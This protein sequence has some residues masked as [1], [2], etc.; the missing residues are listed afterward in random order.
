[1]K[2]IIF[3]IL[4]NAQHLYSQVNEYGAVAEFHNAQTVLMHKPSNE[5]YYGIIH[6]NAALFDT[7]FNPDQAAIEHQKF[8][9]LLTSNGVDVITLKSVLLKGTLD[10]NQQIIKGKHLDNLRDFAR[11]CIR[12]SEKSLEDFS[13]KEINIQNAYLDSVFNLMDP[14]NLVN[15]ILLQPTLTLKKTTTN[16]YLTA[17]YEVNPVMN[18]YF[19]RDQIITTR[20]GI[21]I[22]HLNS[23]QRAI[24]TN[25]IRFCLKK[26]GIKPLL[27]LADG[28]TPKCFLEGGDFFTFNDFSIIGNGMRTNKKAIE[29][30]MNADAFGTKYVAIVK[31]RYFYQPQMH[32]DTYFNIL[33]KD[34]IAISKNRLSTSKDSKQTLLVDIYE[35]KN[36]TYQLIKKNSAFPS[37]LK[38]TLN[39]KLI[40]ISQEDQE[41]YGLNFLTIGPR[42]IIAVKGQ[43]TTYIQQMQDHNVQVQWVDFENLKKGWGA[44]HC[45]TQIINRKKN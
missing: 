26:L 37:F 25:I 40:P 14:Q 35:K 10:K 42:K 30:I 4:F 21:I 9:E 18:L 12:I 7:Y 15:T 39:V 2:K 41:N 16:T 19:S 24:E 36:N 1:M 33:D 11:S 38:E 6:P 31:D 13:E 17:K 43:S 20:K 44:A 3:L 29:K 34:L 45:T 23:P 28:T 8:Q 5:L 27:D 22:T 32:L